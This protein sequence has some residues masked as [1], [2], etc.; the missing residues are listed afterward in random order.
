LIGF[1]S[2]FS[3]DKKEKPR[4][5]EWAR[6]GIGIGGKELDFLECYTFLKL[7][8]AA[9]QSLLITVSKSLFIKVFIPFVAVRST[10]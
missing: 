7:L 2:S 9:G 6:L 10:D 8:Q 1:A 3:I 4:A 5:N